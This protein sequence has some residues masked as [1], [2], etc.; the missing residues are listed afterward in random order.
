LDPARPLVNS[1]GSKLFRLGRDDAHVVQV[2]HSNAGFLG[3]MGLVGHAD[4]CL[5]GGRLQPGCKGHTMRIAR[6]SHFKSCCYYAASVRRQMRLVAVPCDT[7]CP[8][9]P[10]RWGLQSDRRSMLLTE[11]T[12]STGCA[13][14]T[15]RV[16]PRCAP[17]AYSAPPRREPASFAPP[18]ATTERARHVD[19]TASSSNSP[20]ADNNKYSYTPV[21]DF[22]TQ[23]KPS[24][25]MMLTLHLSV[26]A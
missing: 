7:S 3:E 4:F 8:K 5:N 17:L 9:E 13:P 2:I 10:G 22:S 18:H 24:S 25:N 23:S 1:Y 11:D 19:T 14:G 6:C 12:P 16:P 26:L 15:A 20:V 21:H